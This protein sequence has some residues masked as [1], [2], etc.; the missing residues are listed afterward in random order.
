MRNST[1]M[2]KKKTNKEQDTKKLSQE[3]FDSVVKNLLT[4]PPEPKK[5]VP[6]K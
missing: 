5:K 1:I 4:T 2:P 3:E 6:N